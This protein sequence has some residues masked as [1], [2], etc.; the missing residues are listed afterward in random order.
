MII[1]MITWWIYSTWC[2]VSANIIVCESGL[3]ILFNRHRSTANFSSGRHVINDN[4][5]P[6]GNLLST[7]KRSRIGSCRPAFAK[8]TKILGKVAENNNVWRD[9]GNLFTI[10]CICSPNPIS[11]SLQCIISSLTSLTQTQIVEIIH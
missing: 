9:S 6:S 11:N 8:S 4:V 10:S 7:S 5:S 3:I 2:I 1:L